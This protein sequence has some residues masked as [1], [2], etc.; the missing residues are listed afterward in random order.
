MIPPG[1]K[2]LNVLNRSKST[3]SLFKQGSILKACGKTAM[4]KG[5]WRTEL[6]KL[7]GWSSWATE[8]SVSLSAQG[9][10][11]YLKQKCTSQVYTNPDKVSYAQWPLENKSKFRLYTQKCVTAFCTVFKILHTQTGFF[12]CNRKTCPPSLCFWEEF[13]QRKETGSLPASR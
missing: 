2:E 11:L 12:S 5:W 7:P 3:S 10:W 9:I 4:G 13:S 8:R 6:N 1:L